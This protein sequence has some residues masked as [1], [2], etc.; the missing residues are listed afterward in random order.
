MKCKALNARTQRYATVFWPRVP[1]CTGLLR[2][3]S[4]QLEGTCQRSTIVAALH[5][6]QRIMDSKNIRLNSHFL[7]DK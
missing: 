7:T 5:H 6:S 3:G 4:G 2:V 1:C